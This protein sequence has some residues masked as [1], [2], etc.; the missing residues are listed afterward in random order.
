MELLSAFLPSSVSSYT[1]TLMHTQTL[2]CILVKVSTHQI[3]T[4]STDN[5]VPLSYL[6]FGAEQICL[7]Y[8]DARAQRP[9]GSEETVTSYP[10]CM[11]WRVAEG[12]FEANKT[13][14]SVLHQD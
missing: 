6:S 10:R 11:V 9:Q 1:H 14:R 12:R 4:V 8:T 3:M 7:S 2:I 5:A 13:H